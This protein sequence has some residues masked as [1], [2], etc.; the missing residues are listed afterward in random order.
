MARRFACPTCSRPIQWTDAFPFRPFC[1]E[2]CRLIDLGAWLSEQRAIAGD[3]ADDA[4]QGATGRGELP[5]DHGEPH[6]GHEDTEG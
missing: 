4:A 6:Q 2:R 5:E 1:S 3:A